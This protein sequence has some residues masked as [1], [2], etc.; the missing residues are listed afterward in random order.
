VNRSPRWFHKCWAYLRQGLV[1][2]LLARVVEVTTD[3]WDGHVEAVREVFGPGVRVTIDRFHVM[4]NF[5]DHQTA[6]R[7][8][9]Q[10]SLPKDEAEALEGTLW[11]WLTNR[12]NLT[13]EE[14]DELAAL[15]E[16]YPLL[17]DLWDQRERFRALFEHPTIRTA[18]AGAQAIRQWI[19]QARDLGLKA[20]DAFCKTLEHWLDKVANYFVNRASN[21]RAEGFNHGIRSILWRAFGMFNFEH[22]RLRV[23]DRFGRP[24]PC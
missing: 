7:R 24:K 10:R 8:E 20:L 5:Q 23:L 2:G 11:L 17:R 12:E 19:A 13:R 9:I 22:F 6:A 18:A 21:G 16:R 3:M 4:K 15:R 14:R 1:G